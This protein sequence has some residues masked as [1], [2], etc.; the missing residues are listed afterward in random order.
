MEGSAHQVTTTIIPATEAHIRGIGKIISYYAKKELM[1]FRSDDELRHHLDEYIV[2]LIDDKVVGCMGLSTPH[3]G[4]SEIKSVAV[5]ADS[6]GLGIG[7]Q[8]LEQ[9]ERE[10]LK[11]GYKTLFALTYIPTYFTRVG[12]RII[13]KEQLPH[14]IWSDCMQCPKYYNC[15]EI[16][17]CKDLT[18]EKL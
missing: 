13:S 6:Q 17:V 2:A 11:R 8:L 12:W 14:K 1:L 7:A 3:Q 18:K 10:A 16:A 5:D 4:L 15:T 9:C